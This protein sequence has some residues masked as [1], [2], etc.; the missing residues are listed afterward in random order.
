MKK[1]LAPLRAL[2]LI[3]LLAALATPAP[4]YAEG[5]L[6]WLFGDQTAEPASA[7]A[8]TPAP[9]GSEGVDTSE[10]PSAIPGDASASPEATTPPVADS[11][12]EDD[13]LLRVYL[14]SLDSPSQLHLTLRGVYTVESDPGFR[15][16]RDTRVALSALK[17]HVYLAVGGLTIDMGPALTLTR[18]RAEAGEENG[19]TIDEAG[20]KSGLYG[21]DLAV[22]VN[23]DGG[24]RAVLTV[25]VEDYLCGVVAH[26]MSDS[27]PLEALKAQAV[28][29]RTYALRRKWRAGSRD[30]DVVD[31]TA[32]QVYRGYNGEY[33]NVIAAVEATR[34]VVGTWQGGFAMCYYT[35]SNGGQTA[36]A[37]Q[38][39]GNDGDDGYLTMRDDPY[40]L[41]N[42]RSLQNELTVSRRC[43]ESPKLKAL[44]EAA[45]APELAA[46]GFSD[47][48]WIFDAILGVEPV[49]P[50][51]EGSRMYDGVRFEVAVQ[52]SERALAAT[53]A[54]PEPS[55]SAAVG[56]TGTLPRLTVAPQTDA[57][58]PTAPPAEAWVPLEE[59]VAVT[60]DTYAQIKDGLALGLNSADYELISVE[61]EADGDG[62]LKRFALIMRRFGHGVGMSQRGA[63]WMA[64]HYDKTWA[65]ILNY[66]Y[67]GMTLE[68]LAWPEIELTA[69]EALP[70]GVGAARPVPT[71][72]PTPAPLPALEAGEYYAAVTA[73]TLNVRKEPS[74][75]A[76]VLDQLDA[77]RRVIVSGEADADG[78]VPIRTAELTGYVK[79]EY[80]ARE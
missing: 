71:A 55:A 41:E 10:S 69:L 45:L 26:E 47:G 62:A 79:L 38:I 29:A 34:G 19:L 15:F 53:L 59:P 20:G 56:A 60:L 23:G 9:G 57:P 40:D 16:D 70:E 8:P 39:W 80:L 43:E 37:G 21:G 50:R 14:R 3:C 77:G 46:K 22:S 68:R 24:L 58:E 33:A 75:S 31:T 2:T 6:Q 5:L 78:W 63:Q 28:A 72:T 42:P 51:F 48:E 64:G 73:T 12:L 52:V 1:H 4:V 76:M 61:T 30:Y 18:H 49:N 11:S 27:F 35:A 17:G 67:P 74:T 13:G 65:E 54:T 7:A 66:Y 44:L 25:P 32:D 36:L